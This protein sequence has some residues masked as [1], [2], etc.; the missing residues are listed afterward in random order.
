MHPHEI[1]YG[2][3]TKAPLLTSTLSKSNQWAGRTTL[4]SGSATVVVS[5]T[6]VRSDTGFMISLEGVADQGVLGG[7][8]TLGSAQA[9]VTKSDSHINSDS[10]LSWGVQDA[11]VTSHS[12][13]EVHSYGAGYVT[14]GRTD[15]AT[16]VARDV[17]IHYGVTPP[18]GPVAD[19]EVRALVHGSYFTFGRGNGLAAPRDQVINWHMINSHA[20]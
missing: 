3:T 16:D 9:T 14:F 12:N 10:V 4:S 15:A 8:V 6:S 17:T 18:N 20:P 11:A 13:V 7:T 1:L 2:P 5:T 19:I